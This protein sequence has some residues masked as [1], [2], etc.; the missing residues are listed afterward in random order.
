MREL[1]L[2]GATWKTNDDVYDSFFKAV[3]APP[4]H[5]RNFNALNDSIVNG[6]INGIEVPYRLVIINYDQV[7]AGAK[8]IAKDFIELIHEIAE[9]GC[10]IEISIEGPR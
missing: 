9:G 7:G 3:V 6:R 4:W 10:P 5:G 2:D 1:E 8:K